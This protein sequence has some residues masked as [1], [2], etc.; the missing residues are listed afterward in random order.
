MHVLVDGATSCIP[1]RPP[2]TCHGWLDFFLTRLPIIGWVLGYQPGYFIGDI[3]SGITVAIMHI[4][5]GKPHS[6]PIHE[7]SVHVDLSI[8]QL[9]EVILVSARPTYVSLVHI[10]VHVN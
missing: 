7:S 5:Q 6:I 1:C 10:H 8:L 2:S 9:W 3:I 4:P